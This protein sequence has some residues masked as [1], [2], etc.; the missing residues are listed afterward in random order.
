MKAITLHQPW[1]SLVALGQKSIETRS[2][3]TKHRGPIAIH[4]AA[5][6]PSVVLPLS[7]GGFEVD[8][9]NP[10][11]SSPAYLLRGPIVWPYRLPLGSVVAIANLVDVL[12]I[13]DHA[14]TGDPECVVVGDDFLDHCIPS[15]SQAVFRPGVVR[16]DAPDIPNGVHLIRDISGQRPFGFFAPGRYAWMLQDVTPVHPVPAR[17]RQ[18]L[19]EWE[20][21]TAA[22]AAAVDLLSILGPA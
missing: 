17:G 22:L 14:E 1:A 3:A 10:R 7:I 16:L 4:A 5:H 2:W 12:P 8:K 13:T 21:P 11:G 9:D 18:Q 6:V 20:P 19:W 15:S